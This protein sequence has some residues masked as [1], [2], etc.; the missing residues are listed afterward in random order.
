[1]AAP[2]LS[3]KSKEFIV[4][5]SSK[6]KFMI[7][8]AALLFPLQAT[9]LDFTPDATRILT[10]PNYLPLTGQIY[11]YTGYSHTWTDLDTFNYVGAQT[12]STHIDADAIE[13]Y[14]DYGIT[15]DLSVHADMRYEPNATRKVNLAGGTSQTLDSSG[16]SDPTFGA[17]YRVLDQAVNPVNV[18][19]FATYTPDLIDAKV[20]TL[21]ESG[22]LS[23]GGQAGSVGAA[24]GQEMRDFSIRGSM[25]AVF[26]GSRK[27]IDLTDNSAIRT[28]AVTNYVA[29][30]QTQTRLTDRFSVNAGFTY[31]FDNNQN[32]TNTVNGITH[33]NTPGDVASLG[34]ALNYHLVPNTAVIGLTYGYDTFT[35]G[36]NTYAVATQ[37]TQTKNRSDNVV[38]VRLSY[39]L[40]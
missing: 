34:L 17:T 15:D 12:S 16:F 9:A 24:I 25:S 36:K 10:D 40:P 6:A 7:G 1:M 26:N 21:D 39:V 23:S 31:T 18:D 3:R 2:F 32:V 30:L 19:L 22:S 5:T 8:A 4:M 29:S 33:V 35:D 28:D 11:G 27:A 14:L 20:A 13:Q 38:G 37:N